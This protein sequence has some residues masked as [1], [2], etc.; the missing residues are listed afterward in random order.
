MQRPWQL[1]T[2]GNPVLT[3]RNA[4]WSSVT[5]ENHWIEGDNSERSGRASTVALPVG[6][7]TRAGK[8]PGPC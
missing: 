8:P 7:Q 1:P 4:S 2:R 3:T 6:T 5:T